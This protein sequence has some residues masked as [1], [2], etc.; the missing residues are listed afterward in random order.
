MSMKTMTLHYDPSRLAWTH[1][2][3]GVYD[4]CAKWEHGV[5][6]VDA[7]KEVCKCGHPKHMHGICGC[8]RSNVCFPCTRDN[9]PNG[10]NHSG[11]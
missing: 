3:Y 8:G 10:F 1:C 9:G 6:S 7:S 5:L 11:C 2:V 4:R